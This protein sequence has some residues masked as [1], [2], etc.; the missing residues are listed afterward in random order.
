MKWNSNVYNY[1]TTT[2]TFSIVCAPQAHATLSI[3]SSIYFSRSF[4]LMCWLFIWLFSLF[5][6][7]FFWFLYAYSKLTCVDIIQIQLIELYGV[8]V[9][10]QFYSQVYPI[11]QF[12][13]VLSLILVRKSDVIE[14]H[15][16]NCNWNVFKVNCEI[17]NIYKSSRFFSN[18]MV[19][20]TTIIS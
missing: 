4:F 18:R 20:L 8:N 1:I 2:I 12:N 11:N 19:F 9:Q 14:S 16:G 17:M 7:F 15:W 10:K 3:Y 5:F 6:S 13:W